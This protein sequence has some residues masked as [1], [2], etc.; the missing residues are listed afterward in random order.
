[1]QIVVG[2]CFSPLRAY[3]EG[4][5]PK[6]NGNRGIERG[7]EAGR[8]FMA[9]RADGSFTPC[10]YWTLENAG[11]DEGSKGLK[12]L[13]D[14][15]EHS[16]ELQVLREKEEDR[17]SCAGCCYERRCLPCLALKDS[18]CCCPLHRY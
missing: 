15:W 18:A 17:P 3:M 6:R 4:E 10:L 9:L 14:Y 1:M 7:C 8:S 5:D 11:S 12:K 2:S 13:T 16:Q